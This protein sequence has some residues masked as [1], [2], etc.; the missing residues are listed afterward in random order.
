MEEFGVLGRVDAAEFKGVEVDG[1]PITPG[2]ARGECITAVTPDE[3]DVFSVG[4]P[5]VISIVKAGLLETT[6]SCSQDAGVL[7]R[8]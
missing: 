2:D 8:S 1:D 5:I 7:R 4:A 3:W 6:C